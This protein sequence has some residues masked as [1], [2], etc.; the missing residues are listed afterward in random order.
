MQFFGKSYVDTPWRVCAPPRGNPR[1]TTAMWPRT[2]CSQYPFQTWLQSTF[3][4]PIDLFK[5]V[6]YV[7]QTSIGKRAVGPRLKGLPV[8]WL[9]LWYSLWDIFFTELEW[10][11]GRTMEPLLCAVIFSSVIS[12]RMIKSIIMIMN[13]RRLMEERT[14]TQRQRSYGNR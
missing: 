3:P 11:T 4:C 1:S 6:H 10:W 7:A 12:N 13:P 14:G 5:L 2:A 8:L 9:C